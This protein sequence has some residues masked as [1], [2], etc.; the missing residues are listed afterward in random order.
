MVRE[1]RLSPLAWEAA[2][3]LLLGHPCCISPWE[4]R[5]YGEPEREAILREAKARNEIE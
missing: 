4:V 5:D 1:R 2:S 3:S